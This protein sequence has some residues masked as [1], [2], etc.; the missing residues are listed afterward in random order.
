MLFSDGGTYTSVVT[1]TSGKA[2]GLRGLGMGFDPVGGFQYAYKKHF[3][4]IPSAYAANCYDAL[5]IIAYGLQQSKGEGGET[6]AD[7]MMEIVDARGEKTEWDGDGMIQAMEAIRQGTLPDIT[8]ATGP[9]EYDEEDHTDLVRSIFGVWE[10]EDSEFVVK[11]YLSSKDGQSAGS[12]STQAIFKSIASDE[13]MQSLSGGTG[14]ELPEKTGTW[15]LVIATSSGWQNYRHQADALADYQMLR[16]LG[17]SDDN[18]ILIVADDIANHPDNKLPG[19]VR[20]EKEGPNVYKDATIDYLLEDITALD[21]MDILAG[22]ASIRVPKVIESTASD[23]LYVF[24]VGH[25]SR[26]GVFLGENDLLDP[27]LLADT[28][29]NMQENDRFRQVLIKLEACYGGAMG[30]SL[31]TNPGI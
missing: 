25:G 22:E 2:E 5:A 17:L 9:L 26:N 23:N 29:L 7:A 15:A 4:H 10:I 6:L 12:Q 16:S 3:G 21:L 1:E 8:G 19:V 27:F 31:Q 20:N 11:E 24:I 28:F 13:N 30:K 14:S 18:I